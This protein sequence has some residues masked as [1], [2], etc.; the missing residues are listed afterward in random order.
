MSEIKD[1]GINFITATREELC[2][3]IMKLRIE[4]AKH[5]CSRECLEID[6]K[7]LKKTIEVY[8]RKNV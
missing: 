1:S 8:K 3:E 2:Y 7:Y 6:N 5:L 4:I